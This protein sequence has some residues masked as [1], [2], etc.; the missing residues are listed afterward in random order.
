MAYLLGS[1]CST[2]VAWV[3]GFSSQ[4]GPTPLVSHAVVVTH[5]QSRGRLAQMLSQ[6]KSSSAKYNKR[7]RVF[8]ALRLPYLAIL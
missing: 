3:H 7:E 6:G 2:S 1:A 4:C 8:E 5:I